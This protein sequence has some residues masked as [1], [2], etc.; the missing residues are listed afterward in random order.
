MHPLLLMLQDLSKGQTVSVTHE[1]NRWAA[2]VSNSNGATVAFS[3][4]S[5]TSALTRALFDAR[6]ASD[7]KSSG[8]SW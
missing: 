1:N 6:R 2:S 4:E 7:A 5:A 8:S 3:E